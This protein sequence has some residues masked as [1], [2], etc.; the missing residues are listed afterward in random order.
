MTIALSTA[1]FLPVQPLST[2]SLAFSEA[3]LRLGAPL[4]LVERTMRDQ[5]ESVS[6]L[7]GTLGE[8]VLASGGKRMRPALMLLCAEMC[9]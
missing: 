5:L 4:E 9:G 1:R 6:P 7:I 3:L 8:H 2:G